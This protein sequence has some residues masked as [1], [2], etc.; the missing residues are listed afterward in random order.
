MQPG[1]RPGG[2]CR[3]VKSSTLER[4]GGDGREN[5]HPCGRQSKCS[6]D[7]HAH[8]QLLAAAPLSPRHTLNIHKH[9]TT[10]VRHTLPSL[11]TERL[12]TALPPW[13]VICSRAREIHKMLLI[14]D[15]MR[16]RGQPHPYAPH[17]SKHS[18]ASDK[19]AKSVQRCPRGQGDDPRSPN[20]HKRQQN[21]CQVAEGDGGGIQSSLLQRE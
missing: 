18:T 1:S 20:H 3:G 9:K 8:F 16:A 13:S 19:C 17:A 4:C 5:A 12:Q 21:Q 2:L 15:P 14:W 10:Y 7:W 6:P 11:C